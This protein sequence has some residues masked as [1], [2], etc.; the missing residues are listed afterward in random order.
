MDKIK[1]NAGFKAMC[2]AV[3]H[4]FEDETGA[5]RL[6]YTTLKDSGYTDELWTKNINRMIQTF[7]PSYGVNFPLLK[8]F[9]DMGGMS[10]SVK[11]KIAHKFTYGQIRDIGY[12]APPM[13]KNKHSH[14]VAKECIRK[15]GGWRSI[16]EDGVKIWNE[17]E[18]EFIGLYEKL[19]FE[20]PSEK[21]LLGS[22]DL[23][24]QEFLTEYNKNQQLTKTQVLMKVLGVNKMG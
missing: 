18:Q 5:L 2:I 24:N 3:D 21:P 12:N 7:R 8:D 11:S 9:L 20:E 10:V 17:R 14:N 22:S 15:M 23:R 13:F 16:C 1:F 4:K 19:Y 6:Y